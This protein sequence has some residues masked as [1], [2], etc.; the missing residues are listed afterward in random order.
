MSAVN[1]SDAGAGGGAPGVVRG[2]PAEVAFSAERGAGAP[3]QN[4]RGQQVSPWN[5][6]EPGGEGYYAPVQVPV[7]AAAAAAGEGEDSGGTRLPGVV[8]PG[9]SRGGMAVEGTLPAGPYIR[10]LFSSM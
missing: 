10:S 7:A 2:V 9:G 8:S 3:S 4:Q 5:T 6:V 1:P